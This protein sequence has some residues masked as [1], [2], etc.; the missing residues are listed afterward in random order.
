MGARYSRHVVI[1]QQ[2]NIEISQN[3][4]ESGDRDS[5]CENSETVATISSPLDDKTIKHYSKT[6]TFYIRQ[7]K[8]VNLEDV[9]EK[10]KF[11]END[12]QTN[13]F[14]KRHC[15]QKISLSIL[16]ENG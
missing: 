10:E 12:D 9:R 5:E 1:Y 13:Y 14:V 4:Y 8:K 3:T 15:L 11:L 6:N 2:Q 16:W 7:G